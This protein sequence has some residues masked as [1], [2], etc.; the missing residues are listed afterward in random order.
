MGLTKL[1]SELFCTKN[2]KELS[3]SGNALSS[4]PSEIANLE[5]LEELIVR[6]IGGCDLL[7]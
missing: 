6:G 1:P 7:S 5:T 3:L 2:V 4:L